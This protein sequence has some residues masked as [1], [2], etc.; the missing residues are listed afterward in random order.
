MEKLSVIILAAGQ[1]KRMKNPDLP[2]VMVE[3]LDKPL[4]G[5]VLDQVDKLWPDKVVL[6]IGHKREKI[7]EKYENK[8]G[9]EFAIQAEQLGTGHAVMSA[10]DNL[11]S[12]VGS[13]LILLGDVPLLKADTLKKFIVGH[14]KNEA[15]LSV[16]STI[17]P[18]PSGY[19]RIERDSAGN[20]I[21]ITEH[22]DASEEVRKIDEINSGIFLVDNKMLF[23]SLDKIKNNNA[24]GEYYL[25][26]I[27]EVL[28]NEGE[29]ISAVAAADFTELRGINS[30]DDLKDVEQY[31]KGS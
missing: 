2:K 17:A 22:K 4:L 31:L 13:T 29:K 26:D 16:M 28:R 19:G 14:Q 10:K 8:L 27:V 11:K 3:L 18:D 30:P 12:F 1:G 9:I 20:F 21:K 5:H 7:I 24:Q 15:K 6:V 25:T 23:E